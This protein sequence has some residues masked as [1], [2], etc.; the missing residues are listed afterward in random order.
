MFLFSLSEASVTKSTSWWVRL[1]IFHTTR[2]SI[3]EMTKELKRNNAL[4]GKSKLFRSLCLHSVVTCHANNTP[5][6]NRHYSDI[7]VERLFQTFVALY[8]L[9]YL[10]SN[11]RDVRLSWESPLTRFS[12]FMLALS[13]QIM[14]RYE[15]IV[16]KRLLYHFAKGT[17]TLDMSS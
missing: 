13:S 12:I 16:L 7:N 9:F 1:I 5:P 17:L 14:S 3:A 15:R 4:L 10:V 6:K 2:F 8:P 11:S